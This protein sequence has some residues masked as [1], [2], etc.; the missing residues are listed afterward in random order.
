MLGYWQREHQRDLCRL[1]A[2]D[3]LLKHGADAGSLIDGV[4]LPAFV[5]MQAPTDRRKAPRHLVRELL[6]WGAR[7]RQG[8]KVNWVEAAA[9]GGKVVLRVLLVDAEA[10]GEP[11]AGGHPDE[12]V[13]D[14]ADVRAPGELYLD[15]GKVVRQD[16][17]EWL[18]FESEADVSQRRLA[19]YIRMLIDGYGFASGGA[20]EAR[21]RARGARTAGASLSRSRPASRRARRDR[22]SQRGRSPPLRQL[23]LALCDWRGRRSPPQQ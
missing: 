5:L 20:R 11:G 4:S 15:S 19:R 23:E 10:S 7:F 2:F 6:N 22:A 16:L 21:G 8:D 14:A 18:L 12:R 1:F 17:L 13:L 3:A 9:R